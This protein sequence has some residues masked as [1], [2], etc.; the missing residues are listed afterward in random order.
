MQNRVFFI[1]WI[2]VGTKKLFFQ[3]YSFIYKIKE[4]EYSNMEE[5]IIKGMD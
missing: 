3:R 2:K 5:N 1:V 4:K